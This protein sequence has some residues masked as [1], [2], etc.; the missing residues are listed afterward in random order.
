MKKPLGIVLI[1]AALALGYFGF[2]KMNNSKAGVKI[3]DLEIS[4]TDQ[5]S[6]QEAY[7]LFGAAAVCLI[8]GL[9]VSRGKA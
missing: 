6:N 8:A 3:G 9:M 2:T 1:V 7:M 4:A 5:G